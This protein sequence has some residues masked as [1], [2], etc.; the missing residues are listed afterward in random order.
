[1]AQRLPIF[2]R[3]RVGLVY[4]VGQTP[5]VTNMSAFKSDGSVLSQCPLVV[6]DAEAYFAMNPIDDA[7]L[8]KNRIGQPA[9]LQI[10][11][12]LEV[13]FEKPKKRF[14]ELAVADQKIADVRLRSNRLYQIKAIAPGVT[15]V[16]SFGDGG[17][18]HHECV[19]VVE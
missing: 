11:Q 1:M 9:R 15:N 2:R 5:G 17:S 12:S 4:V 7:V 18:L 3:C 6:Q 13:S 16:I 19:V 10:G 14:F 8:C